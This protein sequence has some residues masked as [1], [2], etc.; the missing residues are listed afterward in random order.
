MFFIVLFAEFLKG[1]SVGLV[2]SG[3]GA[4]GL[5]HIG[6]IKALEENN[7][8]ID[9]IVGTSMGAIVGGLYASG[10]TPDEIAKELASKD[11][12]SFY[13]GVIPDKYFYYY[14]KPVED[15]TNIKIKIKRNGWK[16]K[17]QL[18]T[19]YISQISMDFGVCKYFSSATA[20]ANGDFNNLFVPFRC[21]ASDIYHNKEIV[22]SKGDLESA[23]RASSAFPLVFKPIEIDS[24]LYFDGG[25]YNNFP[26]DVMRREFKPDYTIGVNVTSLGKRPTED[27][28]FPQV[29]SLVMEGSQKRQVPEN[30]GIT[31]KINLSNIGLLDF[32]KVDELV[33][34]GYN[35][36]KNFIDSIKKEVLF[37]EQIDSLELRRKNF[38][39]SLPSYTF[40]K[41]EINGMDNKTKHYVEKNFSLN[42]D[43]ISI[44]DLEKQYYKVVSD[45]QIDYA[46]PK[47]S[48]QDSIKKFTTSFKI[49]Q[50][51]PID[52][53]LGTAISS[54]GVNQG[55]IGLNYRF[56][57]EF[58]LLLNANVYFGQLHSSVHVSGRFDFPFKIPLSVDLQINNNKFNFYRGDN[59]LLFFNSQSPIVSKLDRN[60]RIDFFSPLTRLSIIKLGYAGAMQTYNYFQSEIPQIGEK[61]DITKFDY[62]TF[63]LSYVS[64]NTNFL[65]YPNQG[66]NS[67]ISLRYVIGKD[68]YIPSDVDENHIITRENLQWFE[69]SAF[70]ES[71]YKIIKYL[72]F[73]I[74]GKLVYTNK[75]FFSNYTSS[76]LSLPLCTPVIHSLTIFTNNYRAN[77]YLCLG[78][79][80]IITFTDRI[81]LRL[82]T[83][84]FAPYQKIL[85]TETSDGSIIKPY[86]SEN[87]RYIDYI[88]SI[89]LV[90][91]SPIGP[92]SISVNHYTAEKLKTYVMFHFGYYI[93]NKTGMDI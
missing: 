14:K 28:L 34:L 65:H 33:E 40:N 69:I 85:K 91:N 57:N 54:S 1:Q 67:F 16:F 83:Y 27:E 63:Q 66:R 55:F 7:I 17:V 76:V 90:Y 29:T 75:P 51:V 39:S 78:L 41:I 62:H 59:T 48:Y 60:Y 11:F 87:F 26:I 21:V 25:I 18:P 86:F 44:K 32:Q 61:T 6:V 20:A 8:P 46:T 24:V 3:G 42:K 68:T 43:S 30:E 38:K 58:S 82:E 77:T 31:L 9:Y 37:Y 72:S 50:D 13:K 10:Y 74:Y 53:L 71:Y 84:A 52:F 36:C 22:F 79:S 49:K 93:F 64:N 5:V 47:F 92:L 88:F 81:N 35:Y 45:V 2:L 89:N 4:K 80:P 70:N 23:I 73:G 15:A 19:N 12:Y 56:L